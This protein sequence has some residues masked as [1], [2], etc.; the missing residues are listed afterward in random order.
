[1]LKLTNIFDFNFMF[2][3]LLKNYRESSYLNFLYKNKKFA[4]KINYAHIPFVVKDSDDFIKLS[5]HIHIIN[6]QYQEVT[7]YYLPLKDLNN[8]KQ[9]EYIFKYVLKDINKYFNDL[10]R[11]DGF[12][13]E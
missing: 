12:K 3:K 6:D 11:M 5:F 10:E 4:F 7:Y 9:I 13:V 1:M 2:K 8:K